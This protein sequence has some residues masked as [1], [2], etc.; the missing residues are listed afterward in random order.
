MANLF[1]LSI[2]LSEENIMGSDEPGS[3]LQF[4]RWMGG[5]IGTKVSE[6]DDPDLRELANKMRQSELLEGAKSNEGALISR[7]WPT[8]R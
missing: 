6:I 8:L 7:G 5:V 3:P 4:A 1:A 2:I